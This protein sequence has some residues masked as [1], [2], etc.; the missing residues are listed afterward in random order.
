MVTRSLYDRW[1]LI[2]AYLF[3][4]TTYAFAWETPYDEMHRGYGGGPEVWYDKISQGQ[5]I[6]LM[7]N[8]RTPHEHFVNDAV[9]H[10]LNR[11][12]TYLDPDAA[13]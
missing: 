8:P 7:V 5:K 1:F 13:D 6:A 10:H 11:G 3:E 9:F 2:Y 12:V 4:G